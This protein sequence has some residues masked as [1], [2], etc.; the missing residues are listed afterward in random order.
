[1]IPSLLI[2]DYILV[3]KFSYGLR[4]PFTKIWLMGPSLPD[5]GDVVVFRAKDDDFYFMVKRVVGLPGDRIQMVQKDGVD[6]L[7]IN[8]TLMEQTEL[9][10]P[11]DEEDFSWY[12][13]ILGNRK[14]YVQ[15]SK[16]SSQQEAQ[17]FVVP[18]GHIFV[19]GDNRDRSSDSRVWGPLPVE[20]ILGQAQLIWMSCKE[21]S[22]AGGVFCFGEDLRT[23]RL[24]KFIQ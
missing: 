22:P 13:E 5:R 3:T 10:P 19:M 12:S 6:R 24:F 8:G 20:N 17:E 1:M 4:V 7:S 18:K 15:Y 23:E 16:F 9:N 14:H 21:D 2:K 11:E